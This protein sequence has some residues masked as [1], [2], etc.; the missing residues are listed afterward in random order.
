LIFFHLFQSNHFDA[1]CTTT[2]LN[3]RATKVPVREHIK[4]T[5]L[6]LTNQDKKPVQKNDTV[7]RR[8]LKN[9][10][11]FDLRGHNYNISKEEDSESCSCDSCHCE[12]C[13]AE[14]NSIRLNDP[15]LFFRSN[16][17]NQTSSNSSP[18]SSCGNNYNDNI[19]L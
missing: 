2:S 12:L 8:A 11:L 1:D 16:V 14:Q 17:A 13:I 6:K 9:R 19:L 15:Y 10:F 5:K 7:S 3:V 4:G 18:P